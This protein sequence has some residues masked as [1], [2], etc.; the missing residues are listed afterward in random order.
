[1]SVSGVPA[2][3]IFDQLENWRLFNI[4]FTSIS[5]EIL[6]KLD[7][8]F[9]VSQLNSKGERITSYSPPKHDVVKSNNKR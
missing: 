4:I 6:A 1:M 5:G 3:S 8:S 9:K 2:K 7:V